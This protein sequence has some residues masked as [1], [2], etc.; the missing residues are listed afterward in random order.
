VIRRLLTEKMRSAARFAGER[1][2]GEA[3]LQAF[4]ERSRER[5]R[6]P[7]HVTFWQVFVPSAPGGGDATVEKA[8]ALLDNLRETAT[9]PEEGS[10]RGAPFPSGRQVRAAGAEMLARSFGPSFGEALRALPAGGWQGPIASAHGQHLVWITE[11]ENG[12]I[13]ELGEV[14]RQAVQAWKAEQRERRAEA[15]VETLRRSYEIRV[16]WPGSS[17]SAAAAASGGPDA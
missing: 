2:P 12:G 10:R 13:A 17:A 3:E 6:R 1:E 9:A 5:W 4:F 15:F 11:R 14:Q 7:G 16:E 8:R